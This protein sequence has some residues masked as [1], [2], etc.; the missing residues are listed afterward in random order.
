M[1]RPAASIANLLSVLFRSLWLSGR[2]QALLNFK[3]SLP[4]LSVLTGR[5]GY[6]LGGS[7]GAGSWKC[8]PEASVIR[9]GLLRWWLYDPEGELAEEQRL[10][11]DFTWP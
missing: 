10:L 11:Q 7:A 8:W 1:P 2:A 3:V 4:C 5:G 9:M 6:N